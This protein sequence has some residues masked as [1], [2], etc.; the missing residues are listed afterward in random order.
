MLLTASSAASSSAAVAANSKTPPHQQANTVAAATAT[1]QQSRHLTSSTTATTAASAISTATATVAG[2]QLRRRC[3]S[4]QL[5]TTTT[6]TITG[7]STTFLSGSST[8]PPNSTLSSL[9]AK[10]AGSFAANMSGQQSHFEHQSIQSCSGGKLIKTMQQA[11]QRSTTAG[12]AEAAAGAP[13]RRQ[14]SMSHLEKV[15]ETKSKASLLH[16]G[17]AKLGSFQR[18]KAML[19]SP[20]AEHKSLKALSNGTSSSST[21]TTAF[22]HYRR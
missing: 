1:M 17:E 12:A 9:L 4:P 19:S 11:L 7:R 20:K 16:K 10:G 21:C 8:L 6:A 14:A 13:L 15:A 22:E 5:P 3:S 18:L 2:G